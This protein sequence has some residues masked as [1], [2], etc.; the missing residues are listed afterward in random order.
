MVITVTS[1][2][3]VLSAFP[4]RENTEDRLCSACA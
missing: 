3:R 4:A 2:C 1:V